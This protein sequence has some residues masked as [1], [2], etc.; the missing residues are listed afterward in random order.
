MKAAVV[1]FMDSADIGQQAGE[2]N[3]LLKDMGLNLDSLELWLFFSGTMPEWIPELAGKVAVVRMIAVKKNPVPESYLAMLL[4]SAAQ[5]PMDLM[6]FPGS[7]LGRELATRAACRLKGSSC[8]QVLE[9]HP[10]SD[11]LEIIKPVFGSHLTAIFA[12]QLFPCCL[13][14]AR[15]PCGPA[16]MIP[17]DR[18]TIKVVSLRELPCHWVKETQTLPDLPEP[19]LAA[20][21]RVLVVGQGIGSKKNMKKLKEVAAAMGAGIGASR[22]VV[23]NAWA[24]MTRL[25]GISGLILS[26]ELCVVAGVSGAPVFT[27]GIKASEFIVAIN[28]DKTAPIFKTAHVGIVEDL[29]SV[30]TELEEILRTEKEKKHPG[31]I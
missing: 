28:T 21:D 20:A 29:L 7:G 31:Q 2:I 17:P 3:L 12:L 6:I 27:A 24:P 14:P 22:P 26:P 30:L 23:M 10:A 19:G 5:A 16:K 1:L 25:V 15:Q 4:D 9:C 8:L 18:N 11:G 13:S